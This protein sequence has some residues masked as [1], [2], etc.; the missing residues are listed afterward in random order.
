MGLRTAA[1][2]TAAL[3]GFAIFATPALAHR[4]AATVDCKQG[5]VTYE[6]TQGTEFKGTLYLN[7]QPAASWDVVAGQNGVPVSGPL[8]VPYQAPIGTFSVFMRWQF[9]TGE[10]SGLNRVWLTCSAPPVTPTPTP[11]P[12]PPVTVTTPPAPVTA[13]T[14]TPVAT[15]VQARP[16]QTHRRFGV[17]GHPT[18]RCRYGRRVLHDSHGHR[19]TVCKSKPRPVAFRVPSFTG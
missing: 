16:K 7:D 4:A 3:G 6:S 8:A 18:K 17:P 15:T 11:T 14:P 10:S 5:T 2:A 12:V 13:T 19:F 1:V 9:S